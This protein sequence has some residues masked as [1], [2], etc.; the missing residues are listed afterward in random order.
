MSK[1][2]VEGGRSSRAYSMSPS[3]ITAQTLMSQ[4]DLVNIPLK[5]EKYE[6]VIAQFEK[7][8]LIAFIQNRAKEHKQ[9]LSQAVS[10]NLFSILLF[11]LFI[12]A[13]FTLK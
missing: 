4:D 11:S 2:Y 3:K 13:F 12:L 8:D 1:S 7:D 5:Y 6:D 10:E 9:H